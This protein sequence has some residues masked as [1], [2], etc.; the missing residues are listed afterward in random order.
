MCYF[1]LQSDNW[2]TEAVDTEDIEEDNSIY[3]ITKTFSG[4]E[5]GKYIVKARAK[6]TNDFSEWSDEYTF[7]RGMS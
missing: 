4:L 5:S 2:K 1:V 6:D 3:T 7:E